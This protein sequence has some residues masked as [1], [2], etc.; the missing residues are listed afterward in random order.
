MK[1]FISQISA[2]VRA[3][4]SRNRWA[5]QIAIAFSFVAIAMGY[6]VADSIGVTQAFTI[7]LP[8]IPPQMGT[9]HLTAPIPGEP[10]GPPPSPL[11]SKRLF[12]LQ[13]VPISWSLDATDSNGA[14]IDYTGYT[15]DVY[16]RQMD[17]STSYKLVSIATLPAESVHGS[18]R[19]S[20]QWLIPVEAASF[21]SEPNPY[22]RQIYLRLLHA[23]KYPVGWDTSEAFLILHVDTLEPRSGSLV[24]G[25]E[26]TVR[27]ATYLSG[28]PADDRPLIVTSYDGAS[29]ATRWVRSGLNLEDRTTTWKVGYSWN[30]SLGR[31]EAVG[32]QAYWVGRQVRLWLLPDIPTNPAGSYYHGFDND[33]D[34]NDGDWLPAVP[35]VAQ[36]ISRVDLTP[37]SVNLVAGEK[38]QFTAKAYDQAGNLITDKAMDFAWTV[39]GPGGNHNMITPGL[40]DLTL[41]GAYTVTAT[42]G[43]K[44]DSSTVTVTPGI[45]QTVEIVFAL[46]GNGQGIVD[47]TGDP[48]KVLSN[49]EIPF[50]AMAYDQYH[51]VVSQNPADFTWADT[52]TPEAPNQNIFKQATAGLYHVQATY[53]A[54]YLSNIVNVEVIAQ[55]AAVVLIAPRSGV[56]GSYSGNEANAMA[57]NEVEFAVSV[58]DTSGN[59]ITTDPA[60]CTW[61]A[62]DSQG[63]VVP[64]GGSQAWIFKQTLAGD[65]T[66]T[67]TYGSITS[68]PFTLHVSPGTI[69][70]VVLDP[71]VLHMPLPINAELNFTA[72]AY[73]QWD[74]S[75]NSVDRPDKFRFYWRVA[76]G[77]DSWHLFS[78]PFKQA[79]PGNYEVE[80]AYVPTGSETAGVHSNPTAVPVFRPIS[81]GTY[82]SRMFDLDSGS[83]PPMGLSSLGELLINYGAPTGSSVSFAIKFYKADGTLMGSINGYPLN[84]AS[85]EPLDM[86]TEFP[87]FASQVGQLQF[88]IAMSTDNYLGNTQMPWVENLQLIYS[89]NAATIGTLNFTPADSTGYHKQVAPNASVEFDLIARPLEGFGSSSVTVVPGVDWNGSTAGNGSAPAGLTLSFVP[90]NIYDFSPSTPINDHSFKLVM[91]AGSNTPAGDYTFDVVGSVLGDP[92]R[93]LTPAHG[94]VTVTGG[95]NPT[96]DFELQ[97]T[98]PSEGEKRVKPGDMA[99]YRF[100]VKSINS[101]SE[102]VVLTTDIGSK[103]TPIVTYQFFL[104]ATVKPAAGAET[105]V[106]MSVGTSSTSG[107][108]ENTF[109]ITGTS[110]DLPPYNLTGL[111]L[112]IDN[113]APPQV[114]ITVHATIPTETPKGTE[115]P[116]FVFRLYPYNPTTRNAY[117][118]QKTG[119]LPSEF[120][121]DVVNIAVPDGLVTD[122]QKYIGYAKSTRHLWKKSS[123]DFTVN[124]SGTSQIYNL[125]FPQLV[126]GNVGPTP[127]ASEFIGDDIINSLDF[128]TIFQEWAAIWT[129]HFADF[130]NNG[131]VNSTDLAPVLSHWGQQGDLLTNLPH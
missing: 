64:M 108:Q 30:D 86:D 5:A 82:I 43:N 96:G 94:T 87:G 60:A 73:D 125:T 57:G 107:N 93:T 17:G 89:L 46:P 3:N 99:T 100:V 71:A 26:I 42:Y 62:K 12:A 111:T 14:S 67:A 121:G 32:G 51:N 110:G 131:T 97:L 18:R 68:A 52:R 81:S 70:S 114:A 28:A 74:N 116:Q 69:I 20:Y 118:Y 61:Q 39:N 77:S 90:E 25:S 98:S 6:L 95:V 122:A 2:A 1:N 115:Q 130:D 91:T 38:Q 22:D 47:G 85:G 54:H 4:R 124:A 55:E 120:T 123:D 66:V 127:D 104:S 78:L 102:D 63:Q 49:T 16:Y 119:I 53:L 19:N 50:T 8:P 106:L 109:S 48:I 11:L 112:I 45:M 117:I 9:I 37:T 79:N 126:A 88:V 105:L 72:T 36:Q 34:L 103:F 80:A 44:S 15:V 92:T 7:I 29:S 56:G 13:T 75:Y 23:D 129:T 84:I 128:L 59:V 21:M 31:W 41:A 10:A 76:D 27:W 40:F 101:F 113:Q 35:I 24:Y 33:S 65:Y 83:T 58:K